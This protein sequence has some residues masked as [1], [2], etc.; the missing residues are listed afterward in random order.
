MGCIYFRALST[1][2]E[3]IGQ[4]KVHL[5]KNLYM[6]DAYHLFINC[7]VACGKQILIVIH[8]DF[9]NLFCI[10]LLGAIAVLHTQDRV[11]LV[12]IWKFC[13]EKGGV[14]SPSLSQ[15]FRER[16]FHNISQCRAF[17]LIPSLYFGLPPYSLRRHS[18][19]PAFV[20]ASEGKLIF[21]LCAQNCFCSRL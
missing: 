1:S 8:K 16:C 10:F 19:I 2:W 4:Y 5:G 6:D 12:S 13:V 21:Y 14:L 3:V 20:V 11:L 17:C 15:E 7:L 18:N 9:L